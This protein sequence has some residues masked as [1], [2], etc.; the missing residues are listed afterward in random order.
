MKNSSFLAWILRM[1][2]IKR[3]SPMHLMKQENVAEH[4]H[5]VAVI[6]HLLATIKN[7]YCGGQ[8]S[9]EK[10]ATIALY[11]EVSETKL[12]DINH[13]TK[14]SSPA[15]TEEFK[16]IEDLAEIECLNTLPEKLQPLFKELVIQKQVDKE[17]KKLVKAA[18][19]LTA[20]FKACDE[21]K[22]HNP[23]FVSVKKRLSEKVDLCK[24]EMPEVGVF[25]ELFEQNCLAS[26]DD[27]SS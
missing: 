26:L 2:L 16:K 10:A 4:S 19:I 20:Y 6:A 15:L 25:M 3:W 7:V 27:L 8:I 22:F 17:Y 14:Y 9:P 24:E 21:L 12:Q 18:D 5:Q 1:N 13:V 11:H 23:E